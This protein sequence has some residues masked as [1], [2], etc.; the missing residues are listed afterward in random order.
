M[1][2]LKDLRRI[3]K[4]LRNQHRASILPTSASA[5]SCFAGRWR[6]GLQARRPQAGRLSARQ[7]K[8]DPRAG[9]NHAGRTRRLIRCQH[10]PFAARRSR[11]R[12]DQVHD[13]DRLVYA[14]QPHDQ[15]VRRGEKPEQI[16]DQQKR[17]EKETEAAGVTAQPG[18]GPTTPSRM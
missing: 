11:R 14:E 15:F 8:I 16:D 9:K 5:A 2:I 6:P 13:R 4:A 1:L 12:R 18:E 3:V 17:A 10:R 7:A